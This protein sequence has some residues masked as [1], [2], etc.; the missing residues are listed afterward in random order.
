[1]RRLIISIVSIVPIVSIIPI[2]A[3][4]AVAL[5]LAACGPPAP[6]PLR[7]RFETRVYEKA[8]PGCLEDG[9]PD[10]AT[11]RI[12][13]P[14]FVV[15]PTEAVKAKLN[16]AVEQAM[17]APFDE[18]IPTAT[19]PDQFARYFFDTFDA[20]SGASWFLRR[21]FTVELATAN[22]VIITG[23]EQMYTARGEPRETRTRLDLKPN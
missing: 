21:T 18:G 13:Y 8:L 3:I 19:S 10:C 15:A 22:A 11:V 7:I 1:M 14:E 17:L 2:V 4:L 16:A 23:L 5:L 9:K 6:A 12:E 20:G